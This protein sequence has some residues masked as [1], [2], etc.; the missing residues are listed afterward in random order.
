MESDSGYTLFRHRYLGTYFVIAQ[1]GHY[2][3]GVEKLPD[4]ETVTALLEHIS[5]SLGEQPTRL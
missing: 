1:R 2:V 5:E 4:T 3:Y